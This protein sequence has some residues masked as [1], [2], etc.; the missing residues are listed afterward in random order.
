MTFTLIDASNSPQFADQVGGKGA[1][2]FRLQRI[3]LPVPDFFCVGSAHF[4]AFVD[5]RRRELDALIDL[6]P[7]TNDLDLPGLSARVKQVLADR[8]LPADLAASIA[9]R[10][11]DQ[12]SE[13]FSVRSSARQE[14]SSAQSFA[15]LFHTS[16][17]VRPAA[18]PEHIR[19]CWLSAFDAGIL[20]YCR[21]RGVHP[22]D[23]E[24]GVVVQ[25]MVRSRVSGVM[26]TA[27]PAGALSDVV[28]VAGLGLGEG[29]VSDAVESDTF[30][31]DRLDRTI[32]SEIN[33]KNWRIE[34]DAESGTGTRRAAVSEPL[35]TQAALPSE[36]IG[37]L[38]GLGLRAEAAFGDYQDV[39]WAVDDRGAIA[40]LQSRPITT[41]PPGDLTIFD[42]SNI[43]EGYPGVSLPL[44]FSFLK[45]GYGR[46]F[47]RMVAALG[48]PRRL[49]A[50]HQAVFQNMVGYVDGRIYYNLSNWY[51][52]VNLNPVLGR[53]FTPAFNDMIGVRREARGTP[54]TP[55]PLDGVGQLFVVACTLAYRYV[56]LSPMMRR[57][58]RDYRR[59]DEYSRRLQPESM[60]THALS[61]AIGE[62]SRMVFSMIY[63]PLI[64]DLLL[65]LQVALNKGLMHRMGI[66]NGDEVL[67][68]LM[69]GE[70][71]MAS[72]LPVH[73][74]MHLAE[75]LKH[76]DV[77]ADIRPAVLME[78]IQSEPALSGIRAA[79]AEHVRLYGDRCPEELKFETDTFR[80]AP[81]RL[82]ETAL[83]H[84]ASGVRIA[85][86]QTGEARIRGEA[87]AELS[88]QIKGRPMLG[89]ML[90][91]GVGRM[92]MLL[93]NREAG[94]LDRAR[95]VGI[96][97]TL[98]RTMGR[99]LAGERTL[100][101]ADDIYY[102]TEDEIHGIVNGSSVFFDVN[103]LQAA[104]SQR[105]A[106]LAAA[107]S[108]WP[109]ERLT[110][111]GT[112]IRNPVHQARV[113]AAATDSTLTGTPCSPGIVTG[114]AII[115]DDPHT[116]PDVTGNIIVAHMTDPGWVF[117]MIAS[118]GLVV[119]KGSLLSHTAIIGRELGIPTIVGV[120]HA[121][122]RIRSGQWIRIDG[123][124]GEIA[125]RASADVP[126]D[127]AS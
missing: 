43:V 20:A 113:A 25:R 17:Y 11:H 82:L 87:E 26:F 18:V 8:P 81:V 115:V 90:R 117:L 96:F 107:R 108:R 44:T 4:T 84:R 102:L 103:G 50:E 61:R 92:R 80:E 63:R 29:I 65:M 85:D 30:R 62:A 27:D 86:L 118:A 23:L 121:A 13:F 111:R 47:S 22:L 41:I 19:N 10:L 76:D 97:R 33:R 51:A 31:I 104:I 79:I 91:V 78:R 74:L 98:Y 122:T 70:Q 7:Q 15:G 36:V 40:V 94:R 9:A 64:N 73:S 69:C 83:R 12:G 77:P 66:A 100:S 46:N 89:S 109:A 119:E 49:I 95:I 125:L 1:N 3:G 71:G 53:R 112:G 35:A 72:V 116:A 58:Q 124:K 24:L 126:V 127:A 75:L 110:F 59:F 123:A 38:V 57:Y 56:T 101:A 54:S 60:T 14:D 105:K 45:N 52:I 88:R 39:E 21:R 93:R 55:G 16:L 68:G 67:N 37:E 42:N 114:E 48:V 6:L 2:L 99:K 106:A 5:A 120:Q 28:V 32:R 34:F